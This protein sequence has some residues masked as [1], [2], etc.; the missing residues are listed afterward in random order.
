[1]F[2]LRVTFGLVWFGRDVDYEYRVGYAESL[3]RILTT[4]CAVSTRPAEDIH[5]GF[6]IAVVGWYH[7]L[8]SEATPGGGGEGGG[9][10]HI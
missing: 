1:M 2:R 4:P 5:Q 10:Y 8:P 9:E 6:L 7:S 3:T